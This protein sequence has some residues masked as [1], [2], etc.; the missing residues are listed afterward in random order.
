M[1]ANSPDYLWHRTNLRSYVGVTNRDKPP[2]SIA[3]YEIRPFG[4][5]LGGGFGLPGDYSSPSR[6]VRMA[7]MKAFAV[8]GED[9]VDGVSRMFRAFAPVDIPEGL[10]KADPDYDVYEQTLCTSVMCAESGVYYFAPAWNRRI[11]AVR[12]LAE[13]NEIRYFG[14]GD[15]Q[16][17]DYRN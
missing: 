7:F 11:S 4:E 3:G 10:A 13:G 8:Q 1:L 5:H 17:V 16:D 2:Q 6:F 14:L 12:P 15:R 9:E